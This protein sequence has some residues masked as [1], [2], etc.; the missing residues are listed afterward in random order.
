MRIL[1]FALYS[2]EKETSRYS[3]Q[4]FFKFAES[5]WNFT[6]NY[7]GL[8]EYSTLEERKEDLLLF[9]KIKE[10]ISENFENIEESKK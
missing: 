3:I 9:E 8:T 7:V 6:D 5:F 10:L 1:N 4:S 2:D